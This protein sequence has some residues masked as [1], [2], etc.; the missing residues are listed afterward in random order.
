MP[1]P[2]HR[3]RLLR[4]MVEALRDGEYHEVAVV[5]VVRAARTSKRTFYEHFP[6]KQACLVALSRET[7][8]DVIERI[9]G[10][11][12]PTAAWRA[13]VRQAVEALLTTIEADREAHLVLLR[14]VPSL[15]APG[16]R[17]LREAT[18]SFVDLVRALT[19][20][21]ALR[22][23]GVVPPTPGVAVVLFA[24]VR[25]LVVT[26]LED[27]VPL[28]D[29]LDDATRATTALLAPAG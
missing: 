26:A 20:T 15:G 22:D 2:S 11:V 13:Q 8:G 7:V 16:R 25:E 28:A 12:D 27:G 19:D 3:E 1:D 14:T 18:G 21:P 10:A 9:V 4:G 29:V 23:A 24:G 17:L 6:D 5:D